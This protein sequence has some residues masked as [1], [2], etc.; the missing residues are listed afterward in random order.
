M[1]KIK[2]PKRR[3]QIIKLSLKGNTY[4]NGWS[5]KLRPR[6]IKTPGKAFRFLSTASA[7]ATL[8]DLVR[9]N[10]LENLQIIEEQTQQTFIQ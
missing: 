6:F 4:F 1:E 7:L 8:T 3:Y 5:I 2:Q 9:E 10:K